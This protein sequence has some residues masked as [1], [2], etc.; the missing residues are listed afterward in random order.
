MSGGTKAE[1]LKQARI[2][3]GYTS[4]S[5]AAQRFG[6]GEAGYRHHENGTR[7]YGP[8]A[9]KRYGRAFGV[10]PGWLLGLERIND[11]S[12]TPSPPAD[13]LGVNG[14]VAAGIWRES[15]S[16]NDER[17]FVINLPSPIPGAS[18]F[19]LVVEGQSMD[20]AY[21]PGSVLDC[22]SI[23]ERGI[24]PS[25]GDHVIVE[26]VRADGLRELTV[27]EYRE[28]EEDGRTRYFL[29]PRSSR[30]EFKPVEY[31]GPDH[32]GERDPTS[33]ELVQVIAY[34]V[35]SYPQR[36]IELMKRMGLVEQGARP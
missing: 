1:R 14:S 13:R 7:D 22:L 6:W 4:A 18:R 8:D 2:D 9:A 24:R 12:A 31:P 16:W 29:V 15:E 17:R 25:N 28:E 3:A 33:G 36:V 35:A 26:R 23:F 5:E 20:L 34:V 19:G 11:R 32:Q 27:K 10:K 21:E 30:A